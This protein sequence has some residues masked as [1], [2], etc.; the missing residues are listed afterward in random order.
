MFSKMIKKIT[1]IIFLT[2]LFSFW[3]GF[4]PKNVQA[5]LLREKS[6]RESIFSQSVIDEIKLTPKEVL[7]QPIRFNYENS[8]GIEILF[9]N[10]SDQKAE[11]LFRLRGGTQKIL[12]EKDFFL[13]PNS[14][15]GFYF[16][17][18]PGI[19]STKGEEFWVEIINSGNIPLIT[20]YYN[21]NVYHYGE[22]YLGKALQ[23]GVLQFQIHYQI[24]PLQE[25]S[26]NLKAYWQKGWLFFSFWLAIIVTMAVLVII[27]AKNYRTELKKKS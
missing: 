25:L 10:P 3:A 20:G 27:L 18:F 14:P 7:S 26:L 13:E 9:R 22:L 23:P 4:S 12:M 11:G 5:M 16:F 15:A 24:S 21:Q 2:F 8:L 19:E 17:V 6:L 1:I